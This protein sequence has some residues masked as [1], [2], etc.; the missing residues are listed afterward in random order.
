MTRISNNDIKDPTAISQL[1]SDSNPNAP[2]GE[3]GDCARAALLG[4]LVKL[5]QGDGRIAN[6]E[7]AAS[8]IDKL[9]AQA[10]LDPNNNNQ[11]ITN[12]S[13]Q[14]PRRSTSNCLQWNC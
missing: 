3:N 1:K 11:G 13:S 2:P 12:K 9:A 4:A 5:R 8:L 10:G 7:N 6:P 14:K